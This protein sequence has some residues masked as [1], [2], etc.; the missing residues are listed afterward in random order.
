MKKFFLILFSILFLFLSLAHGI[1]KIA[2][3]DVNYIFLNSNAG[4]NLNL[5]IK[6]ETIKIQDG[7]K[8]FK[9]EIANKNNQI[10]SQKNVLSKEKYNIKVKE[11]ESEVKK[12]NLDLAKKNKSLKNFKSKVEYE[13]FLKLNKIIEDYS[14]D[15]SISIILKKENLLMAK[16][17]LDITSDIF[18]LFNEKIKKITI[19]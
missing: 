10:K 3:I 9:D 17:N 11:L 4:K 12:F 1:E 16:K 18:N 14:I 8:K 7:I 5:E 6:N 15:N 19:K 13:F 2:F